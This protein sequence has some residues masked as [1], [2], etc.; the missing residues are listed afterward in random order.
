MGVLRAHDACARNIN[1]TKSQG[2]FKI[3]W[4]GTAEP[5][6]SRKKK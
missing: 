6:T 1:K 5:I 2:R 3:K 4:H